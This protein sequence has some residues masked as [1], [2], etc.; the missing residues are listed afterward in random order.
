MFEVEIQE[1]PLLD[2]L[3]HL[4]RL[5]SDSSPVMASI[6]AV[7]ASHTEANFAAGGIPTWKAKIDGTAATLQ[8][9]GQLAASVQAGSS[10]TE[11]WIGSNK[12]Y[13]AIHQFGGKTK[14]HVIRAKNKKA[15]AFGGR[16]VKQ[17][18]HPGS[19]IP[20]RP[21]LPINAN[22]VLQPDAQIDVLDVIE[23][24]LNQKIGL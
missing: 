24:F 11:A 5:G 10:S 22:G 3:E 15:L 8:D 14:P 4:S 17:V 20:A 13:A 12:V 21:F 9:T 7:L 19:N 6:A 1:E 16:V 18:N 23:A 2:A